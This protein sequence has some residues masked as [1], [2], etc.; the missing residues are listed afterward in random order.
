[1]RNS[2]GSGVP[3]DSERGSGRG[4]A[5]L[6]GVASFCAAASFSGVAAA[7]YPTQPPPAGSP[8]NGANAGYGYPQQPQQGYPQQQYPQQGYPQ[9]QQYPQQGYP[10]QQQYPQQGYPQQP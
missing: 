3:T 10:Q 8:A 7:Q 6:L 9:Q 2:L 4:C 1:M 5:A